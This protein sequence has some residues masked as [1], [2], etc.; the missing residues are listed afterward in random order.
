MIVEEPPYDL[1]ALFADAEMQR[2][3]EELIER[4][5]TTGRDCTRP[6]RWRS[7]RDPQR[8]TVW[9]EPDRPLITFL[10]MRCRFLILWDHH[11]SGFEGRPGREIEDLAIKRLVEAGVRRDMILAVAFDPELEVAFRNV[12]T[13][14]KQVIAEPREILPPEDADILT[15]AQSLR[16]KLR[17][18]ADFDAE[19][20]LHP[21]ELFEALIRLVRLRKA[22]NLYAR[23][24]A[25]VSL[26]AVKRETAIARI[27][28]AISSWFPPVS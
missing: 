6:F 24:G 8:D 3:F 9:R 10:R 19:L 1:V 5:Q 18:T 12:W 26:R 22:P 21:K 20:A 7:L 13:R 23:I 16:P 25:R 27:A 14:I 28:T 4:G 11:G 17:I 15:E 2:L